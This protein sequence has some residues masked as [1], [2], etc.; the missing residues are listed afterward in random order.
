MYSKTTS[1]NTLALAD[2]HTVL[3]QACHQQR[4]FDEA[5]K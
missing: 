3:G 2:V 4:K 1:H 5:I